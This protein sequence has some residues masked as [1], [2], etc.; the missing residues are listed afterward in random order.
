[1]YWLLP[2][3]YPFA[4]GSICATFFTLQLTVLKTK[5][6]ISCVAVSYGVFRKIGNLLIHGVC[7][8]RRFKENPRFDQNLRKLLKFQGCLVR[9][10][11]S[12]CF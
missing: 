3:R 8:P 12:F 9:I 4:V 1:M 11:L 10:K 5:N 2:R 6:S 7:E